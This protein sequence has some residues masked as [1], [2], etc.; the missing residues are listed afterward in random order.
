MGNI[1]APLI[2]AD[3]RRLADLFPLARGIAHV[4]NKPV[5]LAKFTKR[6]D[7]EVIQP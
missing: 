4:F 7:I 1:T 3:K 2:A 5:R 6:E